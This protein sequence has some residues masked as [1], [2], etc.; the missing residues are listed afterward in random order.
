MFRSKFPFRTQ[1][2]E[3]LTSWNVVHQEVKIT[4]ILCETFKANLKKE[5]FVIVICIC[6]DSALQ[7]ER[8]NNINEPTRKGWSISARIVFSEI[9]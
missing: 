2:G 7:K 9:T 8:T 5:M 3:E 6:F 4:G 1:I